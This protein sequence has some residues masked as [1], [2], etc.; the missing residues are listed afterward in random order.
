VQQKLYVPICQ[1]LFREEAAFGIMVLV[2]DL[3]RAQ[4]VPRF[5][6]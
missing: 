2:Y 3:R 4:E 5:V 1:T 6:Q